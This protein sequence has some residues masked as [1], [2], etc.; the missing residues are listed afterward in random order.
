MGATPLSD[1][2]RAQLTTAWQQLGLEVF[3][4]SRSRAPSPRSVVTPATDDRP[5]FAQRVQ[6]ADLRLAD[7]ASVLGS[8]APISKTRQSGRMALEENPI[9]EVAA[10]GTGAIAMGIGFLGLQKSDKGCVEFVFFDLNNRIAHQ[11]ICVSPRAGRRGR[12]HGT[13]R[14]DE[15]DKQ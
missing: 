7:F 10:V 2:R 5:F 9:A 6:F 1:D 4:P 11:M 14:G 3:P 13:K 12:G 15:E 8:S